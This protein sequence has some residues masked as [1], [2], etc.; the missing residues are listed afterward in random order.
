MRKAAGRSVR[1]A[2]AFIVRQGTPADHAA[3]FS[4]LR[5]G[6]HPATGEE[7]P[8]EEGARARRE[9]LREAPCT[10]RLSGQV[11]ASGPTDTVELLEERRDYPAG[12][13]ERQQQERRVRMRAASAQAIRHALHRLER[14]P[15]EERFDEER[16]A[17]YG[18]L[19]GS[20]LPTAS[21]LKLARWLRTGPA[22]RAECALRIVQ[23]MNA[24]KALAPPD[25]VRAVFRYLETLPVKEAGDVAFDLLQH[26]VLPDAAVAEC[27]L[28]TSM[29]PVVVVNALTRGE[30]ARVPEVRA[31]ALGSKE[32]FSLAEPYLRESAPVS[33]DWADI[34][35]ARIRWKP[36]RVRERIGRESAPPLED[37]VPELDDELLPDLLSASDPALRETAIRWA[38]R[39]DLR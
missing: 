22:E 11:A 8:L 14:N 13:T 37:A 33:G 18:A 24:R 36:E 3:A 28:A 9:L 39:R 1:Q 25:F 6:R 34:V 20:P 19:W 27:L 16:R 5:A 38:A 23:N 26:P 30:V 21:W 35:R 17:L 10:W 2:T 12:L 7:A 32:A 4:A 15:S 29:P 31:W